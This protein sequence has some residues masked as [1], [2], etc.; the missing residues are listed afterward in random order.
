[1]DTGTRKEGAAARKE[2]KSYSVHPVLNPWRF[3]P[4]GDTQGR[5][6]FSLCWSEVMHQ[7]E[8]GVI[9]KSCEHLTDILWEE[10]KSK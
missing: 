10:G 3:A 8:G 6:Y 4:C 2:A 7:L 1:M 5:G 9:K